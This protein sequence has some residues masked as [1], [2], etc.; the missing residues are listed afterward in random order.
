MGLT[1]NPGALPGW[2]LEGPEITRIIAEFEHQ[3]TTEDVDETR[4]HE[5]TGAVQK[6]FFEQVTA[7]VSY[8]EESG[9]PFL[10]ASS[11]IISLD[12]KDIAD[13]A[14][15]KTVDEIKRISQEQ[16]DTFVEERLFHR[17]MP[18]YDSI[19]RNKLVLFNS[20][21]KKA[22]PK[23]KTELALAKNDT[24]LFSKLYI[25]CQHRGGDVDEFFKHENQAFPPS[26][27]DSGKLRFSAKSDLLVCFETLV[28][29]VTESP[30]EI[31]A[32]ILDG[33][34][35]V[36][37]LKPIGVT[38]FEQYAQDI[39]KQYI[40]SQLDAVD[41]VG[42]VWDTYK[43]DS[44]KS[45]T[46]ENRGKGIRRR[47]T[48]STAV[49]KNWQDFLCVDDNKEE[50]FPYLSQVSSAWRSDSNKEIVVTDG[51]EV[52]VSPVRD[53]TLLAPCLHEEADTRMFV[54]AA[55]AASRRHKKMIVRTVD[56]DVVVLAVSVFEQLGI[57]EL[58]LDFGVGK[59]RKYIASH[60]VAQAIGRRKS[61]CLPFFHALTGCDTTSSFLGHGKRSAW[62]TWVSFPEVSESFEQLCKAP[63]RPSTACLALNI[64]SYDCMTE[65]VL[66]QV[67]TLLESNYLQRRVDQWKGFLLRKQHCTN[68]F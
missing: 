53:T 41:R 52:L 40:I 24:A 58:W 39:F 11:D 61:K 27:S 34:A 7:L 32:I 43:V 49:P 22:Q 31:S 25:G 15:R 6:T 51:I 19:P 35:I 46:R 1:E 54:H 57:D 48:L 33:A 5:Q 37:M 9:N 55:D 66:A 63:E 56:T 8:F 42:I 36:Q 13:S 38:T 29:F 14:M 4:H 16:F 30:Q 28:P 67:L 18:L 65:Q 26:L 23:G 68:I 44:L 21:D 17:T 62:E 60:L 45:S 47:V 59:H 20:Q 3:L 12:M 50:L 2:M 10:E 64:S